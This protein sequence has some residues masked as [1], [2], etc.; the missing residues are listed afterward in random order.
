MNKIKDKFMRPPIVQGI[1]YPSDSDK[2]QKLIESYTKGKKKGTASFIVTP[3]GG[4]STAGQQI[5][6]AFM[7][8]AGRKIKEIVIISPVH[9]EERDNIILPSFKRFSTAAGILEINMKSLHLFI[10][11]DPSIIRDD[12]PHLEEHAIEDQLPFISS[13]FKEA[14]ILPVLLGKTTISTVK[15]LTKA[16]ERAYKDRLND[17]L[18]VITTNLSL[19]EKEKEALAKA[20]KA[21]NLFQLGDWREICEEKRMGHIDACGAGPLASVMA[22]YKSPLSMEVLS[23][24]TSRGKESEKGKLVSYGALTFNILENNDGAT[25]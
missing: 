11:N 4:Y 25:N 20:D 19:Y 21:L 17:V 16:L 15:K 7:A 5:A 1:F 9:R 22:L 18:F 3:H 23:R 8:A 6:D 14:T 13:L 12:I 10:G 2:L 24:T